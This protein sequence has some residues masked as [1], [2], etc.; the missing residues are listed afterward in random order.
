[1]PAGGKKGRYARVPTVEYPPQAGELHGHRLDDGADL[2]MKELHVD[3]DADDDHAEPPVAGDSWD[4]LRK[5][6]DK[7]AG[8]AP[9]Y[10]TAP[11]KK[12]NCKLAAA[13][14]TVIVA[15][16]FLA[17]QIWAI[18]HEKADGG[19][20]KNNA[21][22][23][24]STG[25]V[26][27]P[28]ST[29]ANEGLSQSPFLLSGP[30][31][32]GLSKSKCQSAEYV[33]R[34]QSLYS[35]SSNGRD[36]SWSTTPHPGLLSESAVR[37]IDVNQDGVLDMIVGV[38]LMGNDV[39]MPESNA[40]CPILGLNPCG[41]AVFALDGRSGDTIWKHGMKQEVFSVICGLLDGNGD[42]QMDC[43]LSG[44]FSQL[45][46]ID[47]R[48]GNT[49][50][51]SF[52][53]LGAFK[54][55][56]L[57]MPSVVDD[58]DDDGV[59]DVVVAQGGDS[60]AS[61]WEVC[62]HPGDVRVISGATGR[63][64]GE[65]ISVPEGR[66]TYMSPVV[67]TPPSGERIVLFGS[68][69]ESINGSLW[70][71]RLKDLVSRSRG[72]RVKKW[73]WLGKQSEDAVSPGAVRVIEGVG[74]G[75]AVPPIFAEMTG[76]DQQD[77]LVSVF[78][79]TLMLIDGKT[80]KV[81][82]KRTSPGYEF[83]S[84]PT[85][86][87]FNNDS[88]PDVLVQMNQ[89][90]WFTMS[91]NHSVMLMLDGRTGE[92]LWQ[93]RTVIAGTRSPLVLRRG[94][95]DPRGDVFLFWIA[96]RRVWKGTKI[97]A[98]D[99]AACPN[100]GSKKRKRRN[101]G[102]A[103]DRGRRGAVD[104][105]AGMGQFVA[106]HEEHRRDK[107][108]AGHQDESYVP[109][110][111]VT[112]TAEQRREGQRIRNISFATVATTAK[113]RGV[114]YRQAGCD[115]DESVYDF[116][117]FVV[118]H[119]HRCSPIRLDDFTQKSITYGAV[120]KMYQHDPTWRTYVQLMKEQRHKQQHEDDHSASQPQQENTESQFE[121]ENAE[122]Q[123]NTGSQPAQE[124]TESQLDREESESRP[125]RHSED[126][127]VEE[128][129]DIEHVDMIASMDARTN[130]ATVPSDDPRL[131]AM[132]R[133]QLMG[134]AALGDLDRDGRYEVL[135]PTSHL[136]MV[137]DK[138]GSYV[139]NE[140]MTSFQ[141]RSLFHGGKMTMMSHCDPGGK[142]REIPLDDPAMIHVDSIKPA[143]AQPWQGYHGTC[144][145]SDASSLPC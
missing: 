99:C 137:I 77:I 68:G 20:T 33:Q 10:P 94:A 6:R 119:D 80:E 83:Y 81:V 142:G 76:D 87:R 36:I 31:R 128:E 105:S 15:G 145:T 23:S 39:L 18:Y 42:G 65:G 127:H 72:K 136:A 9:I 110:D 123:E 46:L 98:D 49:L 63:P 50:W 75:V 61:P 90:Q 34:V 143:W 26:I 43:L 115:V 57:Y 96:G 130:F 84:S 19:N 92:V 7:S 129:N 120:K 27:S 2:E 133:P 86:G 3:A 14:L 91:Y 60:R 132:M 32:Q 1:M 71:I 103:A 125:A 141:A 113:E 58:V 135:M 30:L 55:S 139:R 121:Q 5:S 64:I 24:S 40:S 45:E 59:S 70:A 74:R 22:S 13:L 111:G 38:G 107:R 35:G 73:S 138:R 131:C 117:T 56:N 95:D 48:T 21:T 100:D 25:P 124:N 69:G 108:H 11:P 89:G 52:D 109:P 79:G 97:I 66:E 140:G 104:T 28:T 118:D 47:A 82:W 102:V 62:R 12:G 134:S 29:S 116:E 85:I 41:G 144:G 126:E 17:I 78:D 16:A 8:E 37:L 51:S 4:L 44:R 93:M 101:A 114:G 106:E 67:F 53:Y 88:T 54:I 112:C 122:S